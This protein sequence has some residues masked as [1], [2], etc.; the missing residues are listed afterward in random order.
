MSDP[1][2]IPDSKGVKVRSVAPTIIVGLG[3]TGKEVLL[4]LRRR[5][6]ERYNVFGFPT[7]AY[8]WVDTDTRNV[9]IDDK[10]L[11]HIMEQ[12]MFREEEKVDAQVPGDVFMGYFRDPQTSPHIFSWLDTKLAAQ[13]QVVNGAGQIRPL[14]RLAFFHSYPDVRSKL[15]KLAAAVVAPSAIEAMRNDYRINTD[16]NL[17]DV[18]IVF[19]VAGGTGSGMFL[20]FAFMC[21]EAL[22]DSKREVD[23]TGYT[24]LP[25]AFS[26]AIKGSE[27]IYGNAYAALKELEFYTLRKDLL[28]QTAAGNAGTAHLG[29]RSRHDFAADWE[30][31]QRTHGAPP[32]PMPPPPFNTCY[33][34]DNETQ[35]GGK[36]GPKDKSHLCDMI[37]EDVFLKFSA[38][39]FARRKDSLRSNLEQYLA[40]P[41][42]YRYDDY[43]KAGG[44][45]EVF[46]QRFSSLGFSKLTVPVDRIRRACGYKLSLDLVDAWLRPTDA[47]ATVV[48]E[49]LER[50]EL[51]PLGLRSRGAADDFIAVL[52]SAGSRTFDAVI[53]DRVNEWRRGWKEQA[54]GQRPNLADAIPQAL[55]AFVAKNFD[56]TDARPE[57]WGELV[58]V[59]DQNRERFLSQTR[60][61]FDKAGNREE[62][63]TILRQVRR[64]LGDRP[65]R[66]PLAVEYLKGLTGILEGHSEAYQRQRD[67]ANRRAQE[68]LQDVEVKLTIMRNEEGGSV[69]WRRSLRYLVDLICDKLIDHL[70]ARMRRHVLDA[71]VE[72]IEGQL[73]PYIGKEE[74]KKD[75]QGQDL[76]V[77]E[78][79]VL[80][81]WN[82]QRALNSMRGELRARLASFEKAESHL[83]FDN[84]Y[85]EGMFLNY[86]QIQDG[87]EL[88]PVEAK[89]EELE[90]LLLQRLQ[91]AN[92]YDVRGLVERLT[93][94]KV[95]DLVDEFCYAQFQQL[96]VKADALEVFYEIYQERSERSERLKRLVT[97]A[98][99]WLPE[100]SQAKTYKQ[101]AKNRRLSALISYSE[102]NRERYRE[103]YDELDSLIKAAGYLNPESTTTNRADTVFLYTEC[104]GIP[105]AYVHNIERYRKEYFRLVG[106]GWP[107]HID[108]RDEK[109]ADLLIKSTEDSELTLRAKRCLL[110]GAILKVV[111]IHRSS[112]GEPTFTFMSYRDGLPSPRPLGE[113][114]LAV[115]TLKRDVQL[116]GSVEAEIDR[117][118]Q[119]IKDD[120]D[121]KS[122]LYTLIAY[123]ILDGDPVKERQPGPFAREYQD[124]SQGVVELYSPEHKALKEELAVVYGWLSNG[125]SSLGDKLLDRYYRGEK[126]LDDF[127][128]VVTVNNRRWRILKESVGR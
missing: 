87:H 23:I 99:V 104:A 29:D 8:L 102:K 40:Q 114:V 112:R 61:K 11:D 77:R 55:R 88:L 96:E 30:N 105:L 75:A 110:V 101:I 9:D 115:E 71:A 60:G 57:N 76:E 90:A 120:Q 13:G 41:L 63:G 92:P 97:N 49:R 17:L 58:R 84:L 67:A 35:N 127:S 25:S 24:L 65:V 83:V 44:Y 42:V 47:T 69:V 53:A 118:K 94:E 48:R 103:V 89:L 70:R 107:L 62:D 4:R 72:I 86:Y 12:V 68:A 126:M 22:N 85:K 34:I 36:V 64:W 122:K 100:S 56:K 32:R 31:E 19:S 81:L 106:D 111:A 128:E 52:G 37:A 74:I 113:E 28:R 80:D 108:V 45:T 54:E 119:Q 3:G 20:D 6:F 121:R 82:L 2:P 125:D 5:F 16:P 18:V 50:S 93:Q 15:D 10:P 46:A 14:G 51:A 1:Q 38:E 59:L 98:S 21:R 39:F 91:C 43:G 123:H 33:L 73:K 117:R 116:L 66:L 124:T 78:G 27:K 79:L 95:V 109:F 7:V 26:D